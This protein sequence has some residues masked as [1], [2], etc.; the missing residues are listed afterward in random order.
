MWGKIKG[1][2]ELMDKEPKKDRTT[3][4]VT[5]EAREKLRTAYLR[6]AIKTK[7][8]KKQDFYTQIIEKGLK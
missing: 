2:I 8:L 5:K 7:G 4:T 6:A 1:R 3:I